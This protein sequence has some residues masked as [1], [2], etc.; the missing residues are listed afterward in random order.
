[1]RDN[2]HARVEATA[3]AERDWTQHV[4]DTGR[5]ML[6]TQVDSWMMGI[7]SNVAGKQKRTFIVYAGGAPKYRERCDEVAARGYEG[8]TFR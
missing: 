4:H 3:E 6:F 5:R 8:F 7:N 2:G 1:M